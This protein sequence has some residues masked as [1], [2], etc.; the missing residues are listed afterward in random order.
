MPCP[1][2][3]IFMSL[4]KTTL[5]PNLS[6]AKPPLVDSPLISQKVLEDLKVP[7]EVQEAILK[8]PRAV[9][10]FLA[11]QSSRL[12]AIIDQSE[13]KSLSAAIL[14]P[15]PS[16]LM[17]VGLTQAGLVQA[18]SVTAEEQTSFNG[19]IQE[20]MGLVKAQ[21]DK[22]AKKLINEVKDYIDQLLEENPELEE[23]LDLSED[24]PVEP[25]PEPI[26][27]GT[28]DILMSLVK[29]DLQFEDPKEE[30][31]YQK[32]LMLLASKGDGD[33]LA[34]AIGMKA[35]R[36]VEQRLGK[37]LGA[38]RDIVNARGTLIA[39]GELFNSKKNIA[40]ATK[41]G[42]K[43]GQ[44]KQEPKQEPSVAETAKFNAQVGQL[45]T[46]AQSV[47]MAINQ[48]IS[49]KDTVQTMTQ[50]LIRGGDEF[51]RT[52]SGNLRTG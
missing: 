21:G 7:K 39:Q 33:G 3:A 18:E 12:S 48:L 47:M 26:P 1:Y 15:D 9:L 28:E 42:A 25:E 11:R 41:F 46:Q 27:G 17:P 37:A 32:L 23:E 5:R 10:D 24:F 44:P 45:N 35:T 6:D 49:K 4:D 8:Q 30:E 50:A 14:E 40:D 31:A 19:W 13:I 52:A 20:K 51:E 38:Y 22:E 43:T 16:S 2:R 34:I 36:I 29:S